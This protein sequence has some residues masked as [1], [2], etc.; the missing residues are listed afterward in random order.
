MLLWLCFST[1]GSGLETQVSEVPS[2]VDSGSHP[3]HGLGAASL[4]GC[5]RFEEAHVEYKQCHL[6]S[7]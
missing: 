2:Q 6:W 1:H 3:C 5:L 7:A 4:W